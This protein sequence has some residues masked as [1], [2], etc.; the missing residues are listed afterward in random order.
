[1]GAAADLE[2]S[3]KGVFCVLEVVGEDEIENRLFKAKEGQRSSRSSREEQR[4]DSQRA[5][6]GSGQKE[7]DGSV[8]RVLV[9]KGEQGSDEPVGCSA[10]ASPSA[11]A[12][13]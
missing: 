8:P 6:G 4:A 2:D 3:S 12:G 13:S 11:A 9:G 7:S 10:A 1:V 5:P